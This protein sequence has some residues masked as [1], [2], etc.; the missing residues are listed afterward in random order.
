MKA[1]LKGQPLF[2]RKKSLCYFCTKKALQVLFKVQKIS[3]LYPLHRIL[4]F[5]KTWDSY[6]CGRREG[7][8]ISILE[9]IIAL[10][11]FIVIFTSCICSRFN[12]C[13][14]LLRDRISTFAKASKSSLFLALPLDMDLVGRKSSVINIESLQFACQQLRI[15]PLPGFFFSSEDQFSKQ[16]LVLNTVSFENLIRCEG[17]QLFILISVFYIWRYKFILDSPTLYPLNTGQVCVWNW[18]PR[19]LSSVK[20]L[21]R[22]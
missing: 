9:M 12:F 21:V 18:Y 1:K 5:V 13:L 10:Y 22:Y 6:K 8:Y 17:H 3:K 7:P 2:K 14:E 20:E 16:S 19:S 11:F 15:S 4:R